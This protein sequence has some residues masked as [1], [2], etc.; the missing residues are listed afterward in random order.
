MD[1][2]LLQVCSA[3]YRKREIVIVN[4]SSMEDIEPE[5]IH[6]IVNTNKEK[7]QFIKQRMR[8]LRLQIIQSPTSQYILTH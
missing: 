8:N 6:K 2:K 1:K 4:E 7:A 3:D 5:R